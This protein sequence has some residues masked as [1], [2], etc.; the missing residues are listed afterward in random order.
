MPR[1]VLGAPL[2]A[3]LHLLVTAGGVAGVGAAATVPPAV[4]VP[5]VYI[6]FFVFC[7]LALGIAVWTSAKHPE[8]R[9]RA[10]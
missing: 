6:S 10:R 3:I 1:F 8:P 5:L 4:S 7:M 9:S 2:V